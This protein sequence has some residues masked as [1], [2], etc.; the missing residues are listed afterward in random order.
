MRRYFLLMFGLAIVAAAT[1]A[2]G[3]YDGQGSPHEFTDSDCFLCHFTLPTQGDAAQGR[4]RL[5]EPITAL[6]ARCH[7]MTMSVS[8]KVDFVPPPG[9][10]IPG[11]LP[12]DEDGRITCNTCHDVHKP[13]K[14]PLTGE[15]TYFL[16]R[17]P[18][19]KYFCLACHKTDEALTQIRIGGVGALLSDIAASVSHRPVMDKSHGFARIEVLD[20]G[21]ELDTISLACLDCHNGDG[22]ANKTSLGAGI[23]RHASEG[24]GLSHPIGIDYEKAAWG[25]KELVQKDRLDKRLK[26]FDGKMGCCTCHDPYAPGDGEGLVI[27]AKDS[28]EDLCFA[29]HLK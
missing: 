19:G 24:I 18:A 21:T 10:E 17:E 29:C 1:Y 5:T 26:L 11:D 23:W 6:C 4:L 22:T 3:D 12:L 27:G 20:P 13:S 2:V 8:H 14:N 9:F 28:Y 7:D 16:R 25:D 15:R